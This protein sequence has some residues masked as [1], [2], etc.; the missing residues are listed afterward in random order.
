MIDVGRIPGR[1]RASRG[2]HGRHLRVTSYTSHAP[3]T[4]LGLKRYLGSG[5]IKGIGPKT[6]ERIV[7]H[8]GEQTL[9]VIEL[10]PERLTEV[11]GISAAK[12]DRLVAAWAEQQEIRELMVFL[13]GY[14]VSP[15]LGAKIYK[16]YG[17][18]SIATFHVTG[19]AKADDTS[20]RALRL[21]REKVVE[22]GDTVNPAGRNMQGRCN[23]PQGVFIQ[24]TER[25]LHR[26]KNLDQGLRLIIVTAHSCIYDFP[27]FVGR[28]KSRFREL[29]PFW[30]PEFLFRA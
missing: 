2:Q 21:K 27:A 12:R 25:L 4:P 30:E 19:S 24:V 6:A 7:D 26:V 28:W 22:G 9:A 13:Q 10:E 5:I 14:G 3:V 11:S 16:Q 17:K 20:M 23:K 15:A 8:F 18:H 1:K 29:H